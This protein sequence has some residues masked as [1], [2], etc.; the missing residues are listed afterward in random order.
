[1]AKN[2]IDEITFWW[3]NGIQLSVK[4]LTHSISNLSKNK[5][6]MM[7]NFNIHLGARSICQIGFM[8]NVKKWWQSSTMDWKIEK[9]KVNE[10][11]MEKLKVK[12]NFWCILR[13]VQIVILLLMVSCFIC[14]NLVLIISNFWS[15]LKF[16]ISNIQKPLKIHSKNG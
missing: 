11:K 4:L 1:M 5:I 15:P 3:F 9:E 6:P 2:F 12:K 13:K 14:Q 10:C 7:W 8:Q 16:S